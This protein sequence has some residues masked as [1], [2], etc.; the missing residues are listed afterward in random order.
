MSFKDFITSRLFLKHFLWSVGITLATIILVLMALKG[1]TRHGQSFPVPN[2]YGLTE[3]EFEKVLDKADLKYQV[4]DSTYNEEIQP[5]GVVD[6][7][8]EAGHHVKKNRV[9]Y[10]T[11]NAMGP[12]EVLLPR[13]TDISYRQAVVQL[14]SAG[15]VA[16]KVTYEPS[17]FHN[18]VLK[19]RLNNRDI[20][21]GEA[22]PRGTVIDLVLGSGE[23]SGT[24]TLPDLRGL[25]LNEARGLLGNASL[26]VGSLFY[27]ETVVSSDDS[28]SALI[29]RQHPSTDF[30]FQTAIGSS[31][32]LWLTTDA[33]RV[34]KGTKSSIEELD[35]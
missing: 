13:V 10:L 26:T 27:D 7:I 6:Q 5:G 18:L 22:L 12:E 3:E 9:I 35:F 30:A 15:L 14:E 23:G 11:L 29:F 4:V 28:L 19:A 16:G 24:T 2:V 8:P 20:F 33:A 1:Y 32:D 21:E 34:E 17:E 31:I 25:T